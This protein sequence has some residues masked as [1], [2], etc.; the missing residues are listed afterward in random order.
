MVRDAERPVTPQVIV[1][2]PVA[3]VRFD[4]FGAILDDLP[5][6]EVHEHHLALTSEQRALADGLLVQTGRGLF[7]E[8]LGVRERAKFAQLA[9]G[10][11]YSPAGTVRVEARKPLKVAD[12]AAGEVAQGRPTIVWTNFDEESRILAELLDGTPGLAVLHG[13]TSQPD[14]DRIISRFR[15]GGCDLLITKAQLVGKGLNFQRCKAMVFSGIDDS[16]E[17]FY[18]A[19]RRAYRFGQTDTV[20]VHLPVVPELEG[21]MLSNLKA[22]QA[23]FDA[24]VAAQEQHYVNAVQESADVRD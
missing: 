4:R 22:K 14:R 20:H 21:L 5:D 10:F 15:H 6:P 2:G 24:D 23:R 18:Q 19:V 11:L 16:F 1:D 3:S 12:L 8:R 7:D 17:S 9:R 13:D